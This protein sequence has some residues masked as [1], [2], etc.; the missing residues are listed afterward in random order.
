[1]EPTST[2][3]LRLLVAAAHLHV[4]ALVHARSIASM[5][6]GLR[7]HRVC[8]FSCFSQ[9]RPPRRNRM[10]RTLSTRSASTEECRLTAL[11]T[12]GE[13][14]SQAWSWSARQ[15]REA[16]AWQAQSAPESRHTRA[17]FL[18]GKSAGAYGTIAK[19]R[20]AAFMGFIN[21]CPNPSIE[22]TSTIKLRLL[23]AAPHVKR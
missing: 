8:A 3:K 7:R 23:P 17:G 6:Y 21:E 13:A 18:I 2:S 4:R 5:H 14:V 9:H 16:Q 1:M 20:D 10:R 11:A 19:V 12:A 22:G 15:V